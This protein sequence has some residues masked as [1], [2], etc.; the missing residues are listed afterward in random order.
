MADRLTNDHKMS[1]AQQKRAEKCTHKHSNVL[2]LGSLNCDSHKMQLRRK[3]EGITKTKRKRITNR[4]TD[5]Q[6]L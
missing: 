4:G 2:A 6:E 5:I 1:A 3:K